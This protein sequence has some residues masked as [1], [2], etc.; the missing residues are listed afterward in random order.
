MGFALQ[1]ERSLQHRESEALQEFAQGDPLPIVLNR[2]LLAVEAAAETDML[3]SILLL[4]KN[5]LRH[6][7][8]PNLPRAYCEAI[9]GAEIGPDAG[10]C[11]TA[12]YRG[13]PIYVTDIATDALWNDYRQIAL[14]HGLRACWSTPIRGEH[15]AIVG[16]FAIYHLARR[17]PTREEVEAIQTITD[18]VA[19]AIA[20]S[21]ESPE[22]SQSDLAIPPKP[23]L[24]LVSDNERQPLREIEHDFDRLVAELDQSIAELAIY[25][26]RSVD[27][28]RLCR[29][30]E[31]ALKGAAL[32]RD[33]RSRRGLS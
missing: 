24:Q 30:R 28:E 32:A 31:A 14:E 21:K 7:A 3:T 22:S 18:H 17:S 4:E 9:D 15:G 6:G 20:L 23:A 16:T 11:G 8:A 5:K 25:G 27:M 1:L 2:Y 13:H 12:A 19:R 26:S 33:A 29:A 10:S